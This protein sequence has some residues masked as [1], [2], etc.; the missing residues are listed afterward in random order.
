MS[1]EI[2]I[3]AETRKA[4]DALVWRLKN[5]DPDVPDEVFSLEFITVLRGYGWRPTRARKPEWT[6]G[7]SGEPASEATRK[8]FHAELEKQWWYARKK[9]DGDQRPGS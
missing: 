4:V 3:S 1:S 2:D 5:R 9:S 7:V 6:A 8:A